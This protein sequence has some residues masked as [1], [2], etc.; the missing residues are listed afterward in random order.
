MQQIKPGGH[1]T[2][3]VKQ[4]P[5]GRPHCGVGFKNG[6]SFFSLPVVTVESGEVN[7]KYYCI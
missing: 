3:P 7:T 4:V 1:A 2:S 6:H 5:F